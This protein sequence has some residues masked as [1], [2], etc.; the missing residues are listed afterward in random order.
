MKTARTI[1]FLA[2][3]IFITIIS[4]TDK[5]ISNN[6][7]SIKANSR[8]HNNPS[9]AMPQQSGSHITSS[10]IIDG[11]QNPELIPDDYAYKLLFIAIAEPKNAT[12]E[13]IS[14]AH[15]KI[16]QAGLNDDDEDALITLLSDLHSG[17]IVINSQFA[18]I[19]EHNNPLNPLSSEANQV[20]RLSKQREQLFKSTIDSLPN[21]LSSDG[22]I[23]L[24]DYLQIAKR[25]MII[26]PDN[27]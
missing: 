5:N 19:H 24:R 21:V 13:Q 1:S 22:H 15:G 12:E 3:T 27:N 20:S 17:L 16:H 23:R 18:V 9:F 6:P 11:S 8:F 2:V 25:G 7:L 26:I 10:N 4:S 14:R